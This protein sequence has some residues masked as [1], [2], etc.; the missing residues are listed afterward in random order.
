MNTA[1][2]IKEKTAL[3]N[4]DVF[5]R[6]LFYESQDLL[7]IFDFE[8]EKTIDVNNSVLNYSGYTR[9]EFMKL[10]R[11]DLTPQFSSLK[12]N[13]D[14]HKTYLDGHAQKI[15]NNE[16][17]TEIG[18]FKKKDGSEIYAELEIIPTER[19]AGEA[20]I[21]IKDISDKFEKKSLFEQS[22]RNYKSIVESTAAGIT[23]VDLSGKHL[24]ISPNIEKITGFSPREMLGT[25][26]NKYFDKEE[27]DKIKDYTKQLLRGGDKMQS[28]LTKGKHKKGHTIWLQ[29]TGTILRQSDGTPY[30]IQ[31]V[32][33]DVSHKILLEQELERTNNKYQKIIENLQ[34][35][36][37]LVDLNGNIEYVSP[38]YTTILGY[39]S[40]EVIGK[41]GLFIFCD[42]DAKEIREH[43]QKQL[44]GEGESYT[45]TYKAFHKDGSEKWLSGTF[46][47][48]K[49]KQGNPSGFVSVYLDQTKQV[50][51][52]KELEKTKSKYEHIIENLEG[53]ITI[54]ELNGHTSYVS[55]KITDVLGYQPEELIGKSGYDLFF[56]SEHKNLAKNSQNLLVNKRSKIQH[57]YRGKHKDGTVR[58]ING[59][60]SL[61][62][63]KQSQPIGFVT[64][65]F[66]I[67][68]EIELQQKLSSS[69][70]KYRAL[71]ENAIDPIIIR[72]LKTSQIV[73]CNNA[74]L[75]FFGLHN[76]QEKEKLNELTSRVTNEAGESF[77]EI[78]Q[79]QIKIAQKES[80]ATFQVKYKNEEDDIF[81]IEINM[82]IDTSE[83]SSPR[84]VFFLKDITKQILAIEKITNERKLLNAVIEGTSDQIIV[85][86]KDR[87]IIAVNSNFRKS[88]NKTHDIKID[89]G[90]D[91]KSITL[92][93]SFSNFGDKSA[94]EKKINSVLEGNRIVHQYSTDLGN[95]INHFSLSASP[96]KDQ[97][98][99][100]GIIGAVRDIT[101]LVNKTKEI[102]EKNKEL[103]KYLDSNIQLENFAYIASHDLKQPLRTIISFSELLKSKKS[104]LLDK[105]ASTYLDF[106]LESSQR[107]NDLVNDMLAY[108]VIGTAGQ[109]EAH[110]PE[111]LIEQVLDDLSAQISQK[112]A[113]VTVEALPSSINIYK[114][115][116][117]SL[118]QNLISN[119]IKYSKKDEAPKIKIS[120]KE[121]ENNYIFSVKDNGKGIEDRYLKRIFGMFQRLEVDNQTSGTG[122]GLAH[123]K[124][125][126]ELH[127]GNIWV[128]STL[129]KGST[130][131][132]EIPI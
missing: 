88:F 21:I 25:L 36:F 20:F 72:D 119:S 34:G 70:N 60:A 76:S 64:I 109:K 58:W 11:Y 15:I 43:S 89:I 77:K 13:V 52:E 102:E 31:T 100:I 67:S 14:L 79:S 22:E 9:E 7:I 62:K 98:E 114:S 116:F 110:N 4:S 78:M 69:E 42:K 10:S 6:K 126:V 111:K 57:T 5:F 128:E 92:S 28:F 33:I 53:V 29:G 16:V 129:G 27:L 93:N 131:L 49:D 61:I 103:Q 127:D 115:E 90:S 118:I 59:V 75:S 55:P 38:N 56:E 86:D 125:I 39:E 85:Q 47:I 81:L 45:S 51:I 122:I 32:F 113:S 68:Q 23:T 105:D 3:G 19:K 73:D 112:E 99:V 30:A 26:M 12:P 50:L 63:D 97:D 1:T 94:W 91:M 35:L 106:I 121:A 65:F 46:S 17:I 104:E 66:D 83:K 87:K 107:L 74:A 101:E 8:L 18:I 95:V 2:P 41:K 130:F 80:L 132:F 71:F 37:I 84:C 124:K 120:C 117:I 44:N 108:S 123:C 82:V 40:Q 24:Y 54:T 96:L 48:V